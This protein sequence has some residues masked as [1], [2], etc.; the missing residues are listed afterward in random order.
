LSITHHTRKR[1]STG[2]QTT[3]GPQSPPWWV[4]WQHPHIVTRE[5]RKRKE[6]NKKKTPTSD[7]KPNKDK[8]KDHLKKTSLGPLRQGQRLDTSETRLC[9]S[10]ER[11]PSNQSSKNH[12]ELP[13]HTC[14]LPL[15]QCNSPLTNACKPLEE[16]RAAASAPLWPVRP[17]TLTGQTGG[18]DR[19]TLGNYTGQTGALHRSGWC[20]LGNFQSSKIARNHLKTF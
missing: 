1:P 8:E 6:T 15:N 17:V 5:K 3:H 14:K 2:P 9:W 18:Q 19:P 16:N 20:H 12:K 13:L 10:K 7:R 4:H 11:K